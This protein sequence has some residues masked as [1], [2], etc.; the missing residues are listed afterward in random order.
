MPR[1]RTFTHGVVL[2]FAGQSLAMLAG[3]WLSPFLLRRLGPSGYGL[4]IVGQQVLVYL[5]LMDMGVVAMLPRETAYVTGREHAARELPRLVARTAR[6]LLFQTALIAV[7][8]A[9]LALFIPRAWTAVRVPLVIAAFAFS[10]L[11]P[12]RIFRALLEGLQDLAFIS[13]SYMLS[14]AVGLLVSAGLVYRGF[15]L[16]SLA[17]GWAANQALDALLCFAR[18][19]SR[20]PYALPARWIQPAGP[21]LRHHFARGFWVSVSQVAQVL[22]Y[23]A[24]SAIIGNF[25]GAA[26]VVPYNCTGKLIN[27]LANQPQGIMRAAEPGLSEMRVSAV[28]ERLASV[29]GALTLAMLLASGL[30]V[31]FTL[32]V[33]PGFVPLWMG[34]RNYGGLLLTL[35]FAVSMLLRHLNIAAIYTLF[36]FGHERLL[37]ATSLADGILSTALSILFAWAIHSVVGVLAGSI[38]ST[39]CVLLFGNGR[40]LARELDTSLLNLAKPLAGWFWRMAAAGWAASLLGAAAAHSGPAILALSAALAVLLYSVL[41]FPV[42]LQSSLR[43]YLEPHL[44]AL[45]SFARLTPAEE[46]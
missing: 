44:E 17:A 10:V 24:D 41:M 19:R 38:V 5:S 43:P 27:V 3:L 29:S 1:S 42:A 31:T 21:G 14:W 39:S 6:V 34:A 9:L 26:A 36:A 46:R 4:W 45:R 18:L 20:F 33:N 32:A 11:F 15:R 13:R 2:G 37:A 40:R 8:A 28:R 22:I 25:F 23:G 7:A 30:V 16:E 12:F 35:L